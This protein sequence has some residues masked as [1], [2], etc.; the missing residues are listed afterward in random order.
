MKAM[1]K[2]LHIEELRS[3]MDTSGVNKKRANS[4]VSVE[5]YNDNAIDA[6]SNNNAKVGKGSSSQGNQ[7]NKLKKVKRSARPEVVKAS[8][9][10]VIDSGSTLDNVQGLGMDKREQGDINKDDP[11]CADESSIFGQTTGSSND[12]WVKC[13]KSKR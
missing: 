8:N 1:R 4:I 5:E 11:L 13:D 6:N 10:I 2:R 12:T 9:G 3:V 7:K